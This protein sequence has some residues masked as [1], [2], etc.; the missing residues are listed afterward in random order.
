MAAWRSESRGVAKAAAWRESGM[1]N[2]GMA[3]ISGE[4]KI[5]SGSCQK[6][7]WRKYGRRR[8]QQQ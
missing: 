6:Q 2:G 5:I 3:A 4:S 8:R 1:N 7:Q